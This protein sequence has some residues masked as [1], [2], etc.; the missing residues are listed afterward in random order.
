MSDNN[1]VMD[2]KKSLKSHRKFLGTLLKYING[3]NEQLKSGAMFATWCLHQY[4]N[5]NLMADVEKSIQE[6]I[7]NEH[8]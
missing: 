4:I 5:N 6:S 7:K 3:N 8:H 2:A 1:A